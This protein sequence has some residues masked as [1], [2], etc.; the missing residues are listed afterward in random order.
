MI[1]TFN[2]RFCHDT[3]IFADADATLCDEFAGPRMKPG[4]TWKISL[5]RR[6]NLDLTDRDGSVFI[7]GLLED[8]LLFPSRP[9]NGWETVETHDGYWVTRSTAQPISHLDDNED[10]E[11]EESQ[12]SDDQD[13]VETQSEVYDPNDD[14]PVLLSPPYEDDMEMSEDGDVEMFE[15]GEAMVANVWDAPYDAE[16]ENEA[17]AAEEEDDRNPQLSGEQGALEA[18]ASGSSIT[19]GSDVADQSDS[20]MAGSDFDSDEVLSGDEDILEYARTNG[21]GAA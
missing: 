20:D 13:D 14:G 4:H 19:Q 15:D 10:E 17:E 6:F 1:E 7:E 11:D 2:L 21:R 8:A 9:E 12:S 3:G 16:D 5:G 18:I